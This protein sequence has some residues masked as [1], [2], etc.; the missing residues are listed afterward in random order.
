[1]KQEI[2]LANKS[3]LLTDSYFVHRGL[4]EMNELHELGH[5]IHE[6]GSE[7]ERA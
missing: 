6:G 3:F 2:M 1:M 7:R 5:L 4:N